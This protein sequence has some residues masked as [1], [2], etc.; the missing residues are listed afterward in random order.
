MAFHETARQHKV[1]GAAVDNLYADLGVND[2][3]REAS[4]RGAK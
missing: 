2:S 4:E 3:E 1:A